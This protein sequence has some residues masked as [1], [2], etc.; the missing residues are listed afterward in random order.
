MF[1]W[2]DEFTHRNKEPIMS[3]IPICSEITFLSLSRRFCSRVQTVLNARTATTF[4][5][6]FKLHGRASLGQLTTDEWVHGFQ[7][8]EGF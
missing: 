2:I 7:F 1:G 3:F 6:T 4:P 5:V 8:V